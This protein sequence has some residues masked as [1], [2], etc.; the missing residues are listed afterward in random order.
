[1]DFL[2]D[3]HTY[4]MKSKTD[5]VRKNHI[6]KLN[7]EI[8]SYKKFCK[9]TKEWIGLALEKSKLEIKSEIIRKIS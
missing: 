8:N 4:K 5:Y 6:E 3:R 2:R 7:E 9:L 1:M